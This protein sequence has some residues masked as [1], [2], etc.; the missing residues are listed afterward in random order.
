[1]NLHDCLKKGTELGKESQYPNAYDPKVLF[2]VPRKI[3]RADFS[4][5]NPLPFK[6]ADRWLV[7]ELSYLLPTGKPAIGIAELIVPSDSPYIIESKS[8][9]LYFFSLN[10]ERFA[11]V[12]DLE[13]T[14]VRDLSACAGKSVE[15][16][17]HSPNNWAQW[18]TEPPRG[19]CLDKI[20]VKCTTY[21]VDPS[22]LSD[23]GAPTS[24]QVYTELFR[25]NCPVTGQPD[26]ASIHIS[27]SGP[28]IPQ[29]GLLQYLVSFREHS[30]FHEQCVERIFIDLLHRY[31]LDQLTV[32][33][34]FTRRG[35]L[36]I[37]PLRSTDAAYSFPA[38]QYRQ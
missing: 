20:D 25:S 7:Y 23:A 21:H 9:K 28:E 30:G 31:Q 32:S 22:L 14:L 8:L 1:M 13:E 29:A 11:S 18:Q 6:G 33:G 12:Q 16:H 37:T 3:G 19:D 10:Q 38:R 26:W 4:C 35:G 15:V 24:A 2:G 5:G 17:I 27:Y 34:A 36:D